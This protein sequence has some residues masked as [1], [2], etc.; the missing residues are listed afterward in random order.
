MQSVTGSSI[1]CTGHKKRDGANILAFISSNRELVPG[2]TL[3]QEVFGGV[4]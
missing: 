4:R 2:A 3:L 1:Y